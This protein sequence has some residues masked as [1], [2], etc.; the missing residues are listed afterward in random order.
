MLYP[1]TTTPAAKEQ[2]HVLQVTFFLVAAVCDKLGDVQLLDP[3]E[4]GR[5][6]GIGVVSD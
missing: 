1:L 2:A 3:V 5:E 6:V 4:Q